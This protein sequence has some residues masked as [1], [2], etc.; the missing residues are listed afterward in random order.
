MKKRRARWA[1]GFS[2]LALGACAQIANIDGDYRLT[3]DAGAGG[4]V[5][6]GRPPDGAGS[7]AGGSSA[8]GRGGQAGVGGNSSTGDGAPAGGNAGSSAAGGTTATGGDNNNIG[9][10][11]AGGNAGSSAGAAPGG[12]AGVSAGRGGTGSGGASAGRGG[13]NSAGTSSGGASTGRGGTNSAGTSSGGASAG[14]GGAG[15]G[16]GAAGGSGGSSAGNCGLAPINAKAST[17][18]RN[19]LCYLRK[20]YGNHVLTGQQ[21]SAISSSV[22]TDITFIHDSTGK[23]PAIRGGDLTWPGTADRALAW[24]QA[25]GIPLLRYSMGAPN[26]PDT[27]ANAQGTITPFNSVYSTG[28]QANV[29]FT[30]RLDSAA[31]QLAALQAQGV[32]VLWLPFYDVS[33]RSFWWDKG[34]GA[35]FVTLWAY[36]YTYLTTTKGLNNLIWVYGTAGSA[37]NASYF[38]GAGNVDLAGADTFL[39]DS[40]FAQSYSANAAIVG[41]SMPLALYETLLIPDPATMFTS[42][43]PAAPW[44]LFNWTAGRSQASG[45]LAS[46]Q[47]AFGSSYAI[48][49]DQLPNLN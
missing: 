12:T 35:E 30:S 41:N 24:W 43:T 27:Y 17:Q 28:S 14:R 13:T 49:R 34:S 5:G 31:A 47:T 4:N 11:H 21:E 29:A 48:T 7:G 19:L 1:L 10:A 23:Y 18:A 44:L 38:P 45:A 39:S 3:S 22:E 46:V 20:Q 6:S 42:P 2:A 32:A 15:G 33:L 16:S 8:S 36:T 26:G 40:P 25:G 37:P 9:G